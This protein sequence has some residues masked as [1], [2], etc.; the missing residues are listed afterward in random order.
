MKRT[1]SILSA[2]AFLLVISSSAFAQNQSVTASAQI[3]SSITLSNP[4]SLDFG[5][6]PNSQSSDATI[7]PNGTNSNTG[8]G[9]QF[10]QVN[11]STDPEVDLKIT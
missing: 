11:V 8:T 5:Q 6:I 1:I 10:G 2:L 3:T 7:D 9:S 4:A